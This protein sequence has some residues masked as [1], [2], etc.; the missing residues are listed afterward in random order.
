MG[1]TRSHTLTGVAR[2][3]FMLSGGN[4]NKYIV[5]VTVTVQDALN[6]DDAPKSALNSDD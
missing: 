3:P 5:T 1:F 2:I 4:S 6:S